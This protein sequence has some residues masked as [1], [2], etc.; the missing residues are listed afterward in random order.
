M[1]KIAVRSA[2][3][4]AASID[5]ASVTV[6]PPSSSAVKF[7]GSAQTRARQANRETGHPRP[8]GAHGHQS[9]I[10]SA[11]RERDP[12]TCEWR[13]SCIRWAHR[14]L[15]RSPAGAKPVFRDPYPVGRASLVGRVRASARRQAATRRVRRCGRGCRRIDLG[16]GLEGRGSIS[17]PNDVSS[18]PRSQRLGCLAPGR[19]ELTREHARIHPPRRHATESQMRQL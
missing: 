11:L 17:S 7:G 6:L 18:T 8:T 16:R 14:C 3:L 10:L 9:P 5:R 1:P 15:D 13:S 19:G 4:R 12:V 2:L